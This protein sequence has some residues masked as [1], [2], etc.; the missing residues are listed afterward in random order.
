[1]TP[2]TALASASLKII[3]YGAPTSIVVLSGSITR[4]RTTSRAYR[5]DSW[6]QG[7]GKSEESLEAG[8]TQLQPTLFSMISYLGKGKTIIPPVRNPCKVFSVMASD[9]ICVRTE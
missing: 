5:A 4:T 7:H 9:G 1:M 2:T 8:E 3:W 6:G